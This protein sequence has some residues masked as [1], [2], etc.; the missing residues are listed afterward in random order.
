MVS[1]AMRGQKIQEAYRGFLEREDT[2]K[3]AGVAA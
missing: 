3:K 2:G 1:A